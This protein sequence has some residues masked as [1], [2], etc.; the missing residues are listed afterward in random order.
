MINEY[1]QL[2]AAEYLD[3]LHAGLIG[4]TDLDKR[5]TL[6]DGGFFDA[7][8]LY[9]SRTN[10][11]FL[12]GLDTRN[13]LWINIADKYYAPSITVDH[14]FVVD[15]A[16]SGGATLTA[17]DTEGYTVTVFA[18]AFPQFTELGPLADNTQPGQGV[19]VLVNKKNVGG[20]LGL[21][22]KFL[23]LTA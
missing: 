9:Q 20:N 10:L 4:E 1:W 15:P 3:V 6:I 19:Y 23:T 8:I 18:W 11:G 12:V 13:Q 14:P 22:S 21:P 16:V 7:Q 17:T 5:R 2:V